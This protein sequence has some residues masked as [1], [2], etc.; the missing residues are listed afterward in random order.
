MPDRLLVPLVGSVALVLGFA[1]AQATG[2]RWL[3]G[4][5]LV[6]GAAWCGW[7]WRRRCGLPLAAAA[8]LVYG[9]GFVV[10]HPLGRA[11]GAWPSVALVAIACGAIAVA[12]TGRGSAPAR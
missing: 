1:V 5:V 6:L 12:I 4:I 10:S 9:V 11:I 7:R 3:G 2:V 8:V